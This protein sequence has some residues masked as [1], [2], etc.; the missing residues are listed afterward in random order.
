MKYLKL[1]P[2]LLAVSIGAWAQSDPKIT[3]FVTADLLDPNEVSL[4]RNVGSTD[5]KKPE[6]IGQAAFRANFE[7]NSAAALNNARFIF[8]TS[9]VV[10]QT[11]GSTVFPLETAAF[12]GRVPGYSVLVSKSRPEIASPTCTVQSD[13]SLSCAFGTLL[14]GDKAE[15]IVFVQPPGNG[16]YIK[17]DWQFGGQEGN[18]SGNGCCLN[19]GAP[20]YTKLIDAKTDPKVRNNVQTLVFKGALS[21]LFTGLNKGATEDDP[22]TTI[23][24][25]GS[26]FTIGQT[27]TQA[28][29]QAVINEKKN[30][31]AGISSCSP[32]DKNECWQT[33]LTIA[34]TTFPT[35]DPLWITLE[36]HSSI[37]KNG[38][39]IENYALGFLYSHT[40][41][42]NTFN[43]ILL[44]ADVGGPTPG[45]PCLAPKGTNASA[46]VQRQDPFKR[47]QYI[48]S[49]TVKAVDNGFIKR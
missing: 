27:T 25:L 15:F 42:A 6:F 37:I 46:C 26:S 13:K 39:K 21:E 7:M 8:R 1:A 38:T 41:A 47:S 28:Y 44:C 45:N 49:C 30:L 3:A 20:A 19:T 24:D 12:D 43:P 18:G 29:V 31:D 10:D 34:D 2:V 40:G 32:S 23:A 22:W 5:V 9:V 48:W 4:S 35:G 14:T 17:V 36:R 11:P 16:G 33:Q